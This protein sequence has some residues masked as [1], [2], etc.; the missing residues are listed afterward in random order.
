MNGKTFSIDYQKLVQ[1]IM[2]K[3][4]ACSTHINNKDMLLSFP[5]ELIDLTHTLDESVPSW[6]G[7]CGLNLTTKIDYT[8]CSTDTTFRVQQISMHAGIGTHLD[9]PA[10]CIK[11]GLTIDQMPLSQLIA[12]CFL[13]D[14][15]Q[16]S[17]AQYSLCVKDI[18]EFEK[19][20][21]T[22]AQGSF[23][24]IKTGWQRFWNEP[25]KY[26]NDLN[27][28]SCSAEAAQLLVERNICGL[29]IDTLSPDRPDGGFPVHKIV[30]GAGKYLVE[31][32]ANLDK[33]PPTGSFV[34]IMPLKIKGGTE[35]P[36]RL[37][38]LIRK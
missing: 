8:D 37:I 2:N 18:E 12:P 20:H 23:V 16:K 3:S 7:K 32:A 29:G 28:P 34:M 13:I 9:A 14:I 26:R 30:L 15:S 33:L 1:L 11:G 22:I 27:F 38:G 31:N 17:D 21:G 25:E 10:H 6:D 35:A 36:I 24:M 5:Y 19:L 4:M